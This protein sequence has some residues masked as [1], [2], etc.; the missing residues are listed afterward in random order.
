MYCNNI[1]KDCKIL[2]NTAK[3]CMLAR[4]YTPLVLLKKL[5][6]DDFRIKKKKK[7][8]KKWSKIYTFIEN[9]FQHEMPQK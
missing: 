3:Y 6:R 2:Q 1:H 5:P 9:Y 7:K 4:H 8:K